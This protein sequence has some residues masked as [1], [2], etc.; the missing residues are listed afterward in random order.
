[1]GA[2][3]A[4]RVSS[5]VHLQGRRPDVRRNWDRVSEGFDILHPV[6]VKF[7]VREL[8]EAY[9]KD[10]WWSKGVE[11]ILKPEERQNF[12]NCNSD[13]DRIVKI[14]I[15]L[16]LR[17]ID[18]GANWNQVF[19]DNHTQ[20][21]RTY[22]LELKGVRNK[23]AHRGLDDCTIND[24][25]RWLD[26]MHRLC[27]EADP[28]PDQKAAGEIQSLVDEAL[29]DLVADYEKRK[30]SAATATMPVDAAATPSGEEEK[31]AAGGLATPATRAGVPAAKEAPAAETS[32]SGSSSEAASKTDKP[33]SRTAAANPAATP[34]KAAGPAPQ[35]ASATKA[36]APPSKAT[37]PAS[38]KR[39]A[40]KRAVPS[41]AAQSEATSATAAAPAKRAASSK[42]SQAEPSQ[43]SAAKAAASTRG[44]TSTKP[45]SSSSASKAASTPAAAGKPLEF[46]EYKS[47]DVNI[48]Y[49]SSA[50]PNVE[51]VRDVLRIEAPMHRDVVI[52]RMGQRMRRNVADRVVK[53]DANVALNKVLAD[54]K[55]YSCGEDGFITCVRTQ[56][57]S[58]LPRKAGD[59]TWEEIPP[60]ELEAGLLLILAN[61]QESGSQGLSR[62][63]LINRT[64]SEFMPD[65][66]NAGRREELTSCL[67][68]RSIAWKAPAR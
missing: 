31:A 68:Q 67:P 60:E 19:R 21:F 12:R 22:A 30:A 34:A 8:V 15:L 27:E 26:S 53:H 52:K 51:F 65:A 49:S 3:P 17:I 64:F 47:A 6:L 61:E 39:A 5:A 33:A 44:A 24:A 55:N 63:R 14:D 1:M 28:D 11:P 41:N 23:F 32:T 38:T 29:L 54:S 62:T 42:T 16:A 45:A 37:A 36:A 20:D 10:S 66:E 48:S 9:G 56:G 25:Y 43:G 7:V 2:R 35:T 40:P 4:N 18:I 57:D 46:A 50:D 58:N 13:Y 59:R